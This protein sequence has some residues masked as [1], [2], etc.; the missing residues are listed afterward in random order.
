[1]VCIT[2]LSPSSETLTGTASLKRKLLDDCDLSSLLKEA[3]HTTC[4]DTTAGGKNSETVNKEDIDWKLVNTS[5]S[6]MAKWWKCYKKFSS[7]AHP[8]MGD[9]AACI[10]CFA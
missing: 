10:V 4:V 8:R 1:M 6:C 9:Y 5:A 2:G 3:K 7:V